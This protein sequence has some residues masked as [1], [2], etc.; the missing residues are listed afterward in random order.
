MNNDLYSRY[1][2]QIR[3]S[4][5]S[6]QGQE[7][8]SRAKVLVVGAGALGCPVLM[9]LTAAGVGSIGVLDADE[10]EITNLHRQV[11]YTDE[12]IG[13]PKVVIASKRLT[14]MNP[15]VEV[16]SHF[17]R[18]H[19]DNALEIL[20]SYDLVI[21][22]SDNFS[23]KF[24][25]N[26]ACVILGKPCIIGGVMQFSG[27][28]SVYNFNGGPTYRCL[29]P[30]EPDPL[31]S[32]SCAEAGVI[33]M[34]PGIIGAIQALE[35]LKIITGIGQILSGR[36]LNF[37]G[38]SMTFSEFEIKLNPE[39]LKISKLSEYQYSC[40]DYILNG[41]Q[42]DSDTF[43]EMINGDNPPIVLAFSDDGKPLEAIGYQW[44]TIPLYELPS[45]A[46][47]F[48]TDVD[49]ILACEYG[50][51]SKAALRYLVSKQNFHRVYNLSEGIAGL[52][53]K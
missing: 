52:R 3:V 1:I 53:V 32:P 44:E 42:I 15:N 20:S 4:D 11:I 10:V 34:V 28:L 50:L 48:S 43:L 35:A 12:D 36:L 25:V 24:L 22:C 5:F 37:D 18:L 8:L 9:Y 13:K 23:T 40:P 45:R 29:L 41:R 19:R 51:K 31:E 21:D 49:I 38:L 26:D 33:G 17:V 46:K 7:K 6:N 27:Q 30:E 39:N 14:L 2:R 47:N 16:I